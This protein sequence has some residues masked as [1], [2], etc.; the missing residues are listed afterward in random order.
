M[1]T[2]DIIRAERE[3]IVKQLDKMAAEHRVKA[4]EIRGR[5]KNDSID[6]KFE[7]WL[8]HTHEMQA[9]EL[10]HMAFRILLGRHV[11]SAG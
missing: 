9:C 4:T 11:E 2:D 8:A 5:I 1:N 7:S 6:T 3:A 10:A